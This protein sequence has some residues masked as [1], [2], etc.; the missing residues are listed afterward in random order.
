MQVASLPTN[1]SARLARLQALDVL[2]TEP[3]PELD[4]LAR[5][6]SLVCGVPISLISLVDADRQW[7]KANIGLP[8][9]TQTPRDV[10][11]CAHAILGDTLMEVPDALLDARFSDNPLVAGAPDIRFYAGVPLR[12]SDGLSIGTLC[13]IDRVPRQLDNHQRAI[14]VNLAEAAAVALERRV[15]T[16]QFVQAQMEVALLHEAHSRLAAIIEHSDDAIISKNLQGRVM[17]W[18]ESATRR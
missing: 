13:V 9:A 3:E 6:A 12:M 8:E 10:A 7:C 1:E 17:T 14:L 5:A 18:N 16:K 2:D 4:A 15:R 11:F